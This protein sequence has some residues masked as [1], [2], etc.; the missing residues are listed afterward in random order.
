[1]IGKTEILFLVYFCA[2]FFILGLVSAKLYSTL[3]FVPKKIINC[4]NKSLEET[5][6]CLQQDLKGWYNYNISNKERDMNLSDLKTLGGVCHH[7]ADWYSEN[8]KRLGFFTTEP[9]IVMNDSESHTLTIASKDGTYCIL[10]QTAPI[11][12]WTW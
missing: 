9:Y 11:T 7:Y 12:C 10:D 2:C 5:A 1:M 4:E 6:Q 3:D 8:M